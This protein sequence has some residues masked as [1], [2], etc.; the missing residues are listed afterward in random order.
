VRDYETDVVIN[1]TAGMGAILLPD[2]EDE[3]KAL[4]ES[5]VVGRV[6]AGPHAAL[7]EITNEDWQTTLQ[8]NVTGMF[9]T[10]KHAIPGMKERRFGSIINFSS[11]QKKPLILQA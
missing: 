11:P 7:E 9:Y 10:M 4:P 6:I 8:V 2:P 3:S 1:L 5:D